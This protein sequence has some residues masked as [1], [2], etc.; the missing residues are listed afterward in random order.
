VHQWRD[1]QDWRIHHLCAKLLCT[2]VAGTVSVPTRANLEEAFEAL[3]KMFA[4]TSP[5]G[6][7]SIL[8]SDT[9]TVRTYFLLTLYFGHREKARDLL[10]IIMNTDRKPRL[11]DL[12]DVPEFCEILAADDDLLV[13][14]NDDA[15]IDN[16]HLVISV[17]LNSRA[18][19]RMKTPLHDI[20][21]AELLR[22][23]SEA[24]FF[25][26]NKEYLEN[27]IDKAE[28][29]LRPAL[30]GEE[31]AEVEEKLGEPLP[32]DL[33]ELVL[34]AD[35]FY[36]GWTLAG[37]GWSGIKKSW[38]EPSSDHEMYLGFEA[39]LDR[40][41][42]TETREDGTTHEV[43]STTYNVLV[44][45]S[46]ND[47]GDVWATCGATENDSF[48]H[49]ICPPTTWKKLQTSMG[50]EVEDGA[51]AYLYYSPETDDVEIYPS[52]RAS[53]AAMTVECERFAAV[54][55]TETK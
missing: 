19:R 51:Y 13:K 31:V 49:I 35:G 44:Q 14:Q 45:G 10:N 43:T 21:I 18:E 12:I 38:K 33:K 20:P 55:W 52:M 7:R 37:G 6:E 47:W 8:N 29:V 15:K 53:I 17:A 22:R 16:A 9:Y 24:A 23:F 2:P 28:K 36:G 26:D 5:G 32:P 41:T 27:G 50:N 39:Q 3:D 54:G 48:Q 40:E 34:I 30:T 42:R 46:E 4:V 11:G 25:T 1:S